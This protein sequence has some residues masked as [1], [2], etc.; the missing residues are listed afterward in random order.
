M[1]QTNIF[2]TQNVNITINKFEH[3]SII[4]SINDRFK[5]F[6]SNSIK[7]IEIDDNQNCNDK[8]DNIITIKMIKQIKFLNAKNIINIIINQSKEFKTTMR[9]KNN[10]F[11]K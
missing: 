11:K 9:R 2:T 8:I 10:S 5:T 3:K 7:K 6:Y 1:K 4:K